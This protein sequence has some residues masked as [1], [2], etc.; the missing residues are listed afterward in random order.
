[1]KN[2]FRKAYYIFFVLLACSLPISFEQVKLT[3]FVIMLI[4]ANSIVLFFLYKN[5]RKSL[6]NK[7]VV[8]FISFYLIYLLGLFRSD[9]I[10]NAFFELEKK[11]SLFIFPL[12]FYYSPK[13]NSKE[14]KNILLSF[15]ISCILT[16]T[17]CLLVA[18]YNLIKFNDSSLFFY[19]SLSGIVGMHSIYLSMFLC[20]SIAIF[21]YYCFVEVNI[22]TGW[23]RYLVYA[24][25]FILVITVILLSA[26]VPIIILTIGSIIYFTIRFNK[27]NKLIRSVLASLF[28]GGVIFSIV[29]IIPKTRERFKEG[30]NYNGEYSVDKLG[31]G[32]AARPFIWLSA[33]EI[34]RLNPV[35]GVG[36]GDVEAELTR[37]YNE[38]QYIFLTEPKMKFN[39]HNQFLQTAVEVGLVGLFV[40]VINLLFAM[41]FAIKKKS[42]LYFIFVSIFIIC[43][44]TESLIERERGIIFFAF[45]NS[46][47]AFSLLEKPDLRT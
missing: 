27:K 33:L 26:R 7:T 25:V 34:I 41:R 13:L 42:V 38:R 3:S 37:V 16:S 44:L 30:I 6:L 21:L 4:I 46:F 23:S 45:F 31:Q 9:N 19:H 29:L 22:F 14:V 10:G 47:F 8:L 36:T 40:F 39:A 18:T 32:G 1:M 43:C 2:L 12:I 35:M 28:I 20:F 24:G 5:D 11:L 17:Y 15:A